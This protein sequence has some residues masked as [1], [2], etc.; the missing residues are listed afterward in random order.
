MTDAIADYA[1]WIGC[2]E[3]TDDEL[4]LAPALAAAA[5][6]DDTTTRFAKGSPLPPLW[7][8]FYFLPRAAQ[9]QL[10]VDGHPQRGG[11][12][13]PIPY[14]RRMFAGARMRFHRPLL[15][16]QPARREAVIRDVRQKSGRSGSLAFVSVLC[17]FYQEDVLCIEEEQD[18]VYREPGPV[19]ARPPVIEWPP[20]EDGAWSHIVT[21][22]PKLLFR[23]S[24][25]TFNA[26]RIH[27]DRPYAVEEEGYPGLVVH[28]P[29]T[30]IL[31]IE[32]LRKNSL[33]PVASFSF[34]GLAPLFD[35]APFRLVCAGKDGQ[36]S[37]E[38]QAPDGVVAMSAN[39][40]L[41]PS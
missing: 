9:A 13:P 12:M 38:A 16:G 18:I 5:T 37:L 40:E 11:F 10:D 36:M 3:I 31:L 21:P 32:L 17:R 14:P 23:F 19:L 2:S 8:W 34:R 7:H 26:H 35:L 25:L 4:A 20:V 22:D 41:M 30:A 24:A 1:A 39:A 15:I 33:R 27:Y 29:L 6:L 28:G